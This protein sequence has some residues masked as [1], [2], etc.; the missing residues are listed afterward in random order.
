MLQELI[1]DFSSFKKDSGI[2]AVKKAPLK[3]RKKMENGSDDEAEIRVKKAK[4]V[5]SRRSAA[6]PE[7]EMVEGLARSVQAPPPVKRVKKSRATS[8]P[9]CSLI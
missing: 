4:V 5:G 8:P 7:E 1:A 3:K 2:G 6:I 9:R